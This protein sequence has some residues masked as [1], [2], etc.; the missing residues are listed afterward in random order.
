[1]LDPEKWTD[2]LIKL[3]TWGESHPIGLVIILL[4][5]A[6]GFLVWRLLVAQKR[7]FEKDDEIRTLTHRLWQ[8]GDH[9]EETTRVLKKYDARGKRPKSRRGPCEP[10]SPYKR[11]NGD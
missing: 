1:M 11:R 5:V 2:A 3:G 4:V 10:V 8:L 6:V 7:I 9:D